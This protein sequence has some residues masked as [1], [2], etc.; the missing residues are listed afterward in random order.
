MSNS[1]TKKAEQ[2]L[3]NA[4][5]LAEEY[6]HSYIGTEHLLLSLASM[7]D[8]TACHV[9]KR[10]GVTP[11]KV[12]SRLCAT[13]RSAKGATLSSRDTTP[14]L[15]H[16]IEESY[17]I[18][19]SLCSERIGT[20]HLLITLLCEGESIANKILT[21]L[22][23]EPQGLKND[24]IEYTKSAQMNLD[25]SLSALDE[26]QIPNLTKYGKNMTKFASEVGY[27]PTVERDS[28][29]ERLIRILTRKNKNNPCLIG[30]AGVGKTAIVEGLAMRISAGDVPQSL[31]NKIIISVDLTSMVAGAKYRGDFEERIKSIVKEARKYPEIILFIDEIHTIVG[32]GAAEGA[33]DAANILKP[34]LA[35]GDIKLIGATTISEYRKYIEKD[36]ALERRFQAVLVEEPTK[37]QTVKIL[38]SIRKRYEEYHNAI[39]EDSAIERAVTLSVRFITDRYL[40]DK[41]IDLIDEACAM[42]SARELGNSGSLT[43]SSNGVLNQG[44]NAFCYNS[45]SNAEIGDEIAPRILPR[46]TGRTIEGLISEIT[47]IDV[48]KKASLDI[49]EMHTRLLERVVGQS[50][51]IG[52]LMRA[53]LK[54]T[55]GFCD[56][57]RPKGVFLFL[58]ESGVGKTELAKAL[59]EEL[60]CGAGALIRYDMS[61]YSEPGAVSKIIG[62]SP[63]YVGY[64]ETNSLLEKIRLHPY[65]VVLLDEIEKAHHDVLSLFLNA[66]DEGVVT[67][68]GGRRINFKNTYIIMTSNVGNEAN[69]IKGAPGFVDSGASADMRR[70]LKGYFSEE[71]INRIDEIVLFNRLKYDDFLKIS[72][73]TINKIAKNAASLGIK[74]EIGA[75]VAAHFAR[76][77]EKNNLGARQLIRSVTDELEL[78]IA[79]LLVGK[80]T[81]ADDVLFINTN[82]GKITF[83]IKRIVSV[84]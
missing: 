47:G 76:T 36:A 42:V 41:A 53:I 69:K 39:I 2:A 84:E 25:T 1:F 55:V 23:V 62:A 45:G 10:N 4:Q 51:A 20:E 72:K 15:R 73:S 79:S 28:E 14:R 65:S 68:A 54:S 16:I 12:S 80:S 33:I 5:S 46:V 57:E 3:I 11:D 78:G 83:D 82:G 6:G 35:R 70:A 66:F 49:S 8:C 32:A 21:G 44:R 75:D 37:A 56:Y 13:K 9:L 26:A 22:G 34:E 81:T 77:S 60:F 59:S 74:C 27:E 48:G 7:S 61:E 40:P 29:T 63:G 31:K 18:S 67:D 52:S 38:K 30:E 17:A 71:F 19:K 58:G 50:E 64:D 43:K 24:A